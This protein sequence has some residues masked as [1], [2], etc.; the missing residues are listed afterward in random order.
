MARGNARMAIFLDADDYQ[1][2]VEALVDVADVYALTCIAYCLMPNHYH[3]VL[4]TARANLSLAMRQLNGTYAQAWNR[5]Y[6]RVGHVFQGRFKGQV[7]DSDP[8]LRDVCRYVALNPVRSGL[9]SHARDWPWSSYSG[10]VSNVTREPLVPARLLEQFARDPADARRRY[11]TFVE[12]PEPRLSTSAA[13]SAVGLA[14]DAAFIGR[15][16]FPR[17]FGSE[18]RSAPA[19]VPARVRRADRPTLDELFGEVS[20]R[21]VRNQRIV[22]ARREHGYRLREL[23]DFLGMHYARVSKIVRAERSGRRQHVERQD[24]TLVKARPD[25]Q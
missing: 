3:L 21:Q 10:T 19:E 9:V 2:F 22:V 24:L 18:L 4:E 6:D 13:G 17:R 25:P 15:E 1:R 7:I 20:D 16:D 14:Q 5:R 12:A 8:Y 23:G 11:A